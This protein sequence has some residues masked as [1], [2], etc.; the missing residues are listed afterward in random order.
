MSVEAILFK[1]G[2]LIVAIHNFLRYKTLYQATKEKKYLYGL[3]FYALGFLALLIG[4]VLQL[5]NH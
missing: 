3:L 2:L 1:G 5:Y 4:T